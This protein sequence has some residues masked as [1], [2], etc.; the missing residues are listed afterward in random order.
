MLRE[1]HAYLWDDDAAQAEFKAYAEQAA[2][3]LDAAF[4]SAHGEFATTVRGFKIRGSYDTVEQAQKRAEAIQKQD[5]RFHV[6]VA[7]VGCWC[8]W[9]P[10][11]EDLEDAEYAETQLNTLVKKYKEGAEARDALYNAR[12]E[13]LVTSMNDDRELWVAR[14]REARDP[15]AEPA[16]AS[17]PRAVP[18][19]AHPQN[20]DASAERWPG[21]A[22]PAYQ[23]DE[24]AVEGEAA[25]PVPEAD[26]PE[27]EAAP[28][29]DADGPAM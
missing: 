3:E 7:E 4:R 5:G 21:P 24:A 2:G 23:K 17:V 25:A 6:F 12:K 26:A 27:A 20:L 13:R 10:R 29:A 22:P 8:P 11:V 9:S 14:M 18:D 16:N 15:N 1:R 19:A 28:E